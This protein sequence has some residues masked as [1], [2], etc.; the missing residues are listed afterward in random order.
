MSAI[1]KVLTPSSTFAAAPAAIPTT[2]GSGTGRSG[3]VI[4]GGAQAGQTLLGSV[5]SLAVNSAASYTDPHSGDPALLVHL[6]NGKFVA[7]DAVC[8][9]AGCTVQYDPSQQEI[10][11]PCHGA[12]FDPSRGAAVINGPAQQPLTVLNVKVDAQIMP[13]RFDSPAAPE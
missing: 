4:G 10:V 3:S 9:H 12:A 2:T 8:T 6:A 5:K 13:M 11:C 1:A 7:F